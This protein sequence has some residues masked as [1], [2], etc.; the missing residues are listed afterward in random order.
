MA[1]IGGLGTKKPRLCIY[2]NCLQCPYEDCY[3]DDLEYADILEQD[4][5]DEKITKAREILEPEIIRKRESQR[6]YARSPKGKCASKRYAESEKGKATKKKYDESEKGKER[7]KKY[8]QSEK[9]KL[10]RK[11][12]AQSEKFKETQRKYLQSQK[13]MEMQKI[14]QTNRITSGKNAECCRN[15]YL[16]HREEILNKRREK[17]NGT[18]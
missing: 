9:G 14:K 15:Y 16:R 6:R 5:I 10:A 3:Y 17:R 13:G 18:I 2:P 8:A 11:R 7:R 12:Y 4:K 1:S